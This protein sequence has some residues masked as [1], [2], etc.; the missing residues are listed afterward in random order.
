M[1]L[2]SDCTRCFVAGLAELRCLH[3]LLQLLLLARLVAL[4]PSL[5][6]QGRYPY[7]KWLPATFSPSSRAVSLQRGKSPLSPYISSFL[8]STWQISSLAD[9]I[10]Y[11]LA[12]VSQSIQISPNGPPNQFQLHPWHPKFQLICTW[13]PYLLQLRRPIKIASIQSRWASNLV[14]CHPIGIQSNSWPSN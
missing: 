12:S 4:Q 5:G 1:A 9:S 10:S 8:S 6:K 13:R 2:A 7:I 3:V 14:E 11:G